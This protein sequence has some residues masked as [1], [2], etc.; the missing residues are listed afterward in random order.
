MSERETKRVG[1]GNEMASRNRRSGLERQNEKRPSLEV[2]HPR[3]DDEQDVLDDENEDENE[4][5]TPTPAGRSRGRAQFVAP[6]RDGMDSDED[7]DEES[8]DGKRVIT[9]APG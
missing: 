8:A 5:G 3:E 4:I 2:L 9:G 7:E 1:G 6:P